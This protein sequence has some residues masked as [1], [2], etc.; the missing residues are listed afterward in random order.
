MSRDPAGALLRSRPQRVAGTVHGFCIRHGLPR[1][2]WCVF[3]RH[4]RYYDSPW[5]VYAF[6]GPHTVY[7]EADRMWPPITACYRREER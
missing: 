1:L 6:W 5:R 7:V 4:C 3:D 2:H